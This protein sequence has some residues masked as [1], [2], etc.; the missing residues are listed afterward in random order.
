MKKFFALLAMMLVAI[1][2][3]A[4]DSDFYYWKFNFKPGNTITF[5]DG[6]TITANGNPEAKYSRG[7]TVS[8]SGFSFPSILLPDGDQNTFTAPE[9]MLV[10]RIAFYSY[11]NANKADVEGDCYWKEVGGVEYADAKAS[12][13]A[14]VGFVDN[15]KYDLRYFSIP[16]PQKTVTFTTKGGQF[17]VIILAEY[18]NDE[19]TDPDFVTLNFNLMTNLPVSTNDSHDG[20]INEDQ[21]FGGANGI[22]LTVS[23]SGVATPNRLWGVNATLPDGS[24]LIVPQLRVYGGT[25]KLSSERRKILSAQFEVTGDKFDLT[26]NKGELTGLTW[27]GDAKN[28]V[29][30]V[31]SQTRISSIAVS[32][33]EEAEDDPGDEPGPG[34]E[35]ELVYVKSDITSVVGM[36]QSDWVGASGIYG[37]K[38]TS[39]DG[40]TNNIVERYDFADVGDVMHQDIQGLEAGTYEVT[41]FATSFNAWKG[42]SWL[43]TESSDV[44]YV[45]A[46]VGDQIKTVAIVAGK[47]TGFTEAP[48]YT[49]SD[50]VVPE[51]GILTIGEAL[52]KAN[53]TEWHTIQIYSLKKLTEIH[54]AYAALTPAVMELAN[55]KMSSA[56]ATALVSAYQAAEA[57]L[58]EETYYALYDA[59]AEA[60][61]SAALY[62]SNKPAIDAM[63]ELIASTN[64]YTQEAYD[65]YKGMA[66]DYKL[67]Y[68]NNTLD[69]VVKNPLLVTVWQHDSGIASN[70]FLL[71]A[72]T[73]GGEQAV[74]YMRSLY[75]NTWSH[76]GETD[77]TNFLVPFYEYWNQDGNPLNANTIQATV[78]GLDPGRHYS[79]DVWT[80]IRK[81]NLEVE[82]S[83]VTFAV[84]DGEAIAVNP[85]KAGTNQ[86]FCDTI[87][88]EGRADAD[89]KLTITFTVAADNNISWLSF[90]DVKYTAGEKDPEPVDPNLDF[91]HGDPVTQ[92]ICTYAK[93][94]E[95]N[96]TTLSQL[97]PVEGWD[98]AVEN[99]DARAAG[100]FA[101][102]SDATAWLGGAGYIA[103]AQ[104]PEDTDG[105]QA[106]GLVA[107]WTGTAQY[108]QKVAL[109]PGNYSITIPIYNSVGGTT[110]P[111]KSLFG[112]IADDGTEYLAPAKAYPV[113]LWTNEIINFTLTEETSGVISV[114]YE[115]QNVG[116]G[117]S[118]HLFIDRVEINKVS[119]DELARAALNGALEDVV[120]DADLVGDDLFQI[121]TS[122]LETFLSAVKKATDVANNT[123]LTKADY[124]QALTELNA[125]IEAYNATPV[126]APEEGAEYIFQQKASGLYLAFDTENAKV[127][128]SEIPANLSFVAGENGGWFLTNGTEYVGF[129]GSDNW[130]MS[131]SQEYKYEWA[132]APAGDDFYYIYKPSNA[133][134]HIGTNDGDL[135]EGAP[136]Y[137][138][139][140]N[141][142]NIL[143]SIAKVVIPEPQKEYVYTD[144]TEDMFKEWDGVTA[145]AQVV[146][147]NPGHEYQV[148]TEVGAGGTIYGNGS[149]LAK[150]YADITD[151]DVM[152]IE[153]ASGTPRL[154]FN[155]TEDNSSDF[156]EINSPESPYVTVDENG[157]WTIDLAAIKAERGFVHLNVM[158]AT[159]GGAA[160]VTA[161]KLGKEKG[162]EPENVIYVGEEAIPVVAT[163]TAPV[164]LLEKVAYSGDTAAFDAAA[165]AAALGIED[166][167]TATQYFLNPDK[168]T[169][170]AEYGDGTFDG[171]RNAEGF[172]AS[173]AESANGLCAKIHDPASGLIDYLGAHDANFAEGD[174]YTAGFAF[175]ADGKAVILEA[176]I[177]FVKLEELTISEN[178]YDATVSYETNEPNY[179]QKMA[180]L[181]DEQVAAICAELGFESLSEATVYAYNPTTQEIL[182][183]F[184]A[185]DGWRNAAGDFAMHTGDATVPACVKYTDGQTYNCYNISGCE[186]QTI[187][188]YWAIANKTTAVLVKVAFTY[189]EPAPVPVEYTWF[190]NFEEADENVKIVGGGA[191]VDDETPNFGKVF[192]NVNAGVRA[193]YITLPDTLFAQSTLSKELSIAFWVNANGNT[194][195]AYTYAPFFTAY[196]SNTE[197]AANSWPMLALQSR[198]FAQV[199]CNGW[200]DFTAAENVEGKNNLYNSNAW[201]AGDA[202]FN[203]V[204]NW[205]EDNQWHF[206][207]AVFTAE[208][209]TIY[210]DGN[211][212]NQ[213]KLGANPGC[214][215]DG[216]FSDG[217]DLKYICLG[218]NQA[219]DWNDGDAP[220]RFDDVMVTNYVLTPE[221]IAEIIAAKNYVEPQKEYV[222]TDLT[223][224]MFKEWDSSGADAQVVNENP[225]REYQVGSEVGAG[226][227]IYGNVNVA[228][229]LYADL[230]EYD[231]MVIEVASGT[232]RLL[233][234]RSE[235]TSSDFIEINSTES[236]YVTVDENGNWI[237]N[238]AAIKAERGFVHLNV[239]KATWGGP[240]TVTSIKL[241]KEKGDEPVPSIIVGE[242]LIPIIATTNVAVEMIEKR[243]YSGDTAKFDAAAIAEW[244]GIENLSAA[245]QYFV[246][247]DKTAVLA[248]YGGGTI[249]GWR[250]SEGFAAMWATCANGLCAKIQDP[251]SG[252]IDYL[253]EHDA[254]FSAGDTFNTLFAFVADG[255]AVVLSVD[256]TFVTDENPPQPIELEIS[257]NIYELAVEYNT[258]DESYLNKTVSLTDDQVAAILEEL[259][260][261]SLSDATVYAYNPTTQEFI[262]DFVAFDGWR[263]V[264]GDFA[265]HTG[266]ATVPACVKYTDGQNYGCWNINGC[267]QQTINCY[268]AIANETKAVLVKIIFSYVL[269]VGIN[270]IYADL[271]NA[272]IYDLNG[273]RVRVPVKGNIYIVNGKK[274]FLK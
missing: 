108:T 52:G 103:P 77:G 119:D 125:A 19:G 174:S 83:G 195:D 142:D 76:E 183:D 57:E 206:Y 121:P 69:E 269:P 222:Y 147:N 27:N 144:L 15:G 159:W 22:S 10:S 238:L 54:E 131:T 79:V 232:P 230:T 87:Q 68:D 266:D 45:Y 229:K 92:G 128:L 140:N 153:V 260:L 182:T 86:L 211:V 150:L 44:A 117:A 135:A 107:V 189:V 55:K 17:G 161:I 16:T 48:K 104:G 186:P 32:L 156:L 152:V 248:E 11:V 122:A 219:W 132:I 5:S 157:N 254:T 216:L 28:I 26:P 265:N 67:K 148:G 116:S 168:T 160:T 82:E 60:Q 233:F 20:D 190:Y 191:I 199:N 95:T 208:G 70:Q 169:V 56:K 215:L 256:V 207:T 4:Q 212:K 129:V 231:H 114:G 31:N 271:E 236:P 184:A 255:K 42:D 261:A 165:I 80:R 167:S 263:N 143:W 198:G 204:E 249:D 218:G 75:I 242:E 185:F 3:Q 85:T 30:T 253:G 33:G 35:P 264:D 88:A 201:E 171:W 213:W 239:I 39:A 101:Y 102:G 227:T 78:E 13:G 84:G 170:L 252:I 18:V 193:N 162:D 38:V 106:L 14:M 46:K 179:T 99:G 112:F 246:N 155:R 268:W 40:R 113:N 90:K 273:Q 110:P 257:D 12:G 203:F 200:T 41:V 202:N 64:V 146:N 209:L 49:I 105:K 247:P 274:M 36:A 177:S 74:D 72:W 251:A 21:T 34:P 267:E 29:F 23:P 124:E 245:T 173:W 270:G 133:N 175:V 24:T 2:I 221:D 225:W 205:L 151:Y 172:A 123:E 136:C 63:Y 250:N 62:E 149:V 217:A 6:S 61:A 214:T 1:G 180:V 50:I 166:L 178:V 73:I 118:P 47:Q 139:K 9:G 187:D 53:Q 127:V 130:T 37:V 163:I 176:A 210:L 66:D 96:H 138:D 111:A 7:G 240:A 65:T 197:G 93:D 234:D 25:I 194:P 109:E 181:T 89:G 241:G 224:D 220:F 244:L 51:G 145:D 237:I 137:A 91:E 58:T 141:G 100:I 188:C 243:A 59:I 154:L 262:A 196:A 43:T 115:S 81:N 259:G 71:S 8:Y 223:E 158:K 272:V 120:I 235:D 228:A 94:M 97:Q 258:T 134:H 126:N 192:E 164:E 98:I 226:G